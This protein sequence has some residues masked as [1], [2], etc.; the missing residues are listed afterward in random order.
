MILSKNVLKQKGL[1]Y[2]RPASELVFLTKKEHRRL[3][4]LA[5]TSKYAKS[6]KSLIQYYKTENGVNKRNQLSLMNKTRKHSDETKQKISNSN[7][8]KQV[9]TDSRQKMSLAHKGMPG[10]W[11]GKTMSNEL[12]KKLRETKLQMTR[13]YKEYKQKDGAL[14]WKQWQRD[15]WCKI[16]NTITRDSNG[17]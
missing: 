9:S 6:S 5:D 10:F 16:K 13:Y 15:E 1:Y 11:T 8:G 3:H 2:N 17:R 4:N 14:S 7:K 12:R